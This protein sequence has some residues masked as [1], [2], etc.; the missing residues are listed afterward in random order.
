MENTTTHMLKVAVALALQ[1][2]ASLETSIREAKQNGVTEEEFQQIFSIV[3]TQKLSAALQVDAMAEELIK[4]K[5]VELNVL[6]SGDGACCCG[7]DG[8]C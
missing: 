8:C 1:H 6:A 5:Q 7:P 3:R 4:E 2:P